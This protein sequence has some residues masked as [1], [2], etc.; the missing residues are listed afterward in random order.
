MKK[1]V[2]GMT[3]LLTITCFGRNILRSETAGPADLSPKEIKAFLKTGPIVSVKKDATI[4]RTMPW[5]ITLDDGQTKLQ[6]MFKRVHAPRPDPAVDSYKYELAAY[7]LSQLL[8]L[9]IIPPTVEREIEGIKGSLQYF[10]PGCISE[11]DRER[12]LL[13]PPDL[14]AFLGRLDEI[15]VFEALVND[16]CLDKADILIQQP[17]WNVYRVDFAEAFAPTPGLAADC[18]ITRCPRRLF[19][20][21]QNTARQIIESKLRPYLSEDEIGTIFD[22]KKRIIARLEGLMKTEGERNVLY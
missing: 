13:Q 18:P 5:K 6:G 2:L 9:E 8:G 22:R 20:H 10:V 16:T 4:G 14:K 3:F 1:I 7:E 15:K 11:T 17:G 12:L 21:L 19:E